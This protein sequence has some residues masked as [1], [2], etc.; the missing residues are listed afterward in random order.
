MTLRIKTLLIIGATLAGLMLVMYALAKT[1]L[2]QGFA[3]L[4]DQT[5]R[6]NVRRVMDAL[7]DEFD[8]L[9][10]QNSDYARWNDTCA[11]VQNGNQH[12][13][14]DNLVDLTFAD[15]KINLMLFLNTAGRVVHGKGY[16]LIGGKS[17]PAPPSLLRQLSPN[18]PLL[19][20]PEVDSG[21]TG[22]VLL[23]EGPLMVSSLP[24]VTNEKRGP[25]RGALIFGKYLDNAE[26]ERLERLTH[27]H[28]DLR[29]LGGLPL[30]ADYRAALPGLAK[31][32]SIFVRPLDRNTIAG[33]FL[34]RDVYQNPALVVRMSLPRAIYR[35]G[36]VTVQ[37]LI[38]ALLITAYVF[39]A[40]SLVLLRRFVL[41]P[42]A[43]LGANAIAI[44]AGGDP[45]ARVPVVGRDELSQL[46]T[47]INDM[48]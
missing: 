40:V 15:L 30:P 19:R 35:Q 46:S 10:M 36:T 47:A 20:L 27:L 11:F 2:L 22:L 1:I 17:V 18:N 6:R 48:L 4:E 28:V 29:S 41:T 43:R 25:I 32:S 23:E 24:V 8:R 13:I 39:A 16:D 37:Y 42:L 31:P 9:E 12:Y 7:S 33:Y 26:T 3:E 38:H 14:R 44:G 34:L 45:S 5:T 21:V